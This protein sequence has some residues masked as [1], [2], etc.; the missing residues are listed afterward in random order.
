MPLM[1]HGGGTDAKEQ[2]ESHRVFAVGCIKSRRLPV[3]GHSGTDPCLIR[4]ARRQLMD[5]AQRKLGYPKLLACRQEREVTPQL[6]H[7][8]QP[9][10]ENV[11]VGKVEIGFQQQGIAI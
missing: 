3:E 7:V 2:P 4:A 5:A 1:T 8:L 9:P 10:E 6:V 11:L